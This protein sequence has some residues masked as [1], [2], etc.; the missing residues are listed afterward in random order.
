MQFQLISKFNIRICF[1]LCVIDIFSKYGWVIPLRDEKGIITITNA[2]QKFLKES[3]Q[4]PNKILVYKGSEFY[5]RSKKSF[6]R[7]NNIEIYLTRNE[8]KSVTAER[9]IRTLNNKTYKYMTSIS[10]SLCIDELDDKVKK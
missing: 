8:V 10:K 7:I 2:F 6:L 3:N 9:F 4:K 5:N 1:L